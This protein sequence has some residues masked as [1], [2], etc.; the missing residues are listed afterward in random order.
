MLALSPQFPAQ[1]EITQMCLND[2]K[3]E[4]YGV[5]RVTRLKNLCKYNK[6]YIKP[7]KRTT[8]TTAKKKTINNSTTTHTSNKQ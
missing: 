2:N 3:Q 8:S 4:Q 1:G 5:V 7:T 6:K